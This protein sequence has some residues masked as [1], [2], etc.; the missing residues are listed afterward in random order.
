MTAIG[1]LLARELGPDRVF[2]DAASLAAHRTDYWILAHL[3]ARQ[4]RLAGGPACVVRPRSTAEVVTTVRAA[5][6]HGVPIVPYGGG[7]GVVGGATPPAGALV[8]DLR[9][10]DRILELNETSL[11]ARIEAGKLGGAYEQELQVRGYSS[12]HFPQSIDLATVGGF[13][14]T[15]AAGQFST[16]YGNIEDLCLGLEVVLASGEVVRIPPIPRTAAGPSLRELFL[17]SEGTL[18][19]ITEVALRVHPLPERRTLAS[20]A[21][22]SVHAAL[23]CVRRV[24]RAGWRPAVVRAYD[25]LESQRHFTAW[26]PANSAMLIVVSEGPAALV[27]AEEAACAAEATAG[28]GTATGPEAATRWL[29]ERNKVPSWDFFLDREMLADTIEV[30]AAWDRVPALYDQVVAALAGA[31]GV[32]M[33]SGHSSHGY[34]QGTNIYFTFVMKP[35][36]FARAEDDYL[37]AWGRALRA[38][39]A[40]GGTTSHHHGIGRLRTPW[41]QEELGS[42]YP[43]LRDLKRTLDPSGLLNPGVLVAAT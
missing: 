23:D 19:I 9:R 38:T 5:Q 36:D 18:G 35:A 30:A 4:G 31:P 14:A 20:Y 37:E 40:V 8:V 24:L 29:E 25:P 21:F 16:R 28:G 15:R 32:V 13:V 1:E 34:A 11:Y 7:S 12:G 3:R 42:A 41:L 33:A 39:L 26:A 22:P 27:A 2:E 6:R 17:G 10:L 43:L